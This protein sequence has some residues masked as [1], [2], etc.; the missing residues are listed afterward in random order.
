MAEAE[1]RSG[2]GTR[3]QR[4]KNESGAGITPHPSTL[5]VADLPLKGGG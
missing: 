3:A 4:A 1:L 5:R 2:G